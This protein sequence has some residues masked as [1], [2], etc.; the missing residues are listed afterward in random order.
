MMMQTCSLS[1][2]VKNLNFKNPKWRMTAILQTVKS[3]Y[4]QT[5]DF[6]EIWQDGAFSPHTA[7]CPYLQVL[8]IQDGKRWPF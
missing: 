6:D 3:A 8:Y 4:L 2:T 5:T 7:D 1:Q